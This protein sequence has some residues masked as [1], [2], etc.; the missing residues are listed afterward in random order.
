M[1]V[2]VDKPRWQREHGLSGHLVADSIEELHEM[3]TKLELPSS[4]FLP[5]A[6]VPHYQ[7]PACSHDEAIALGAI[8]LE[9]TAFGKALQRIVQE[10]QVDRVAQ[11][12]LHGLTDPVRG[13]GKKRRR[14]SRKKP[15]TEQ[16]SLV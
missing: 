5:H 3:A 14:K 1:G 16:L 10:I 4:N 15:A 8:H 12:S 7:L 11:A 13:R 2:Y 6:V 9:P